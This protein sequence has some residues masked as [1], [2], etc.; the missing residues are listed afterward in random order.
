MRKWIS[1]A[2]LL[3]GIAGVGI[4]AWSIVR[5]AIYQ[6]RANREF[7]ERID[8]QARGNSPRSAQS[9]PPKSGSLIG[10]L[11]IPRLHL[12]EMVREG[13][14]NGTLDVALGHVPGTAL[15]GAS[16]NVGI[17]GHR[18]TLFRALRNI[19]R[20][21]LIVFQTTH[22]TYL[23]DVENTAIVKPQNVGV[24]AP[25]S[26]S[27]ITLVT[28]YPFHYVGPAPDRFIVKARLLSPKVAGVGPAR[29]PSN[30]SSPGKKLLARRSKPPAR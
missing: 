28:C 17:A 5:S 13:T 16:G 2:L 24:L 20:D 7:D 9:S 4:W 11:V 26:H 8:E 29:K 25:G 12:H 23:Y 19:S 18:D 15:P 1:T 30:S 27:E 6:S 22:G 10:R 3:A 21:D 14:D